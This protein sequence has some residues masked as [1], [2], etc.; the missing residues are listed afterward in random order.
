MQRTREKVT[1]KS[2]Q[3]QDLVKRLSRE[4]N[5]KKGKHLYLNKVTEQ[6][7]LMKY[8]KM[9]IFLLDSKKGCTKW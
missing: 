6:I 1:Q 9:V 4:K 8:P 7:S 5:N 2:R 3:G